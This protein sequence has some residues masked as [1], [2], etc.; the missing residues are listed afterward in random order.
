MLNLSAQGCATSTLA[1]GKDPVFRLGF[2]P[3]PKR[4]KRSNYWCFS[5]KISS[6]RAKDQS[7]SS[8]YVAEYWAEARPDELRSNWLENLQTH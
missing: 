5:A 8:Y 7:I 6:Y 1:P 3:K 2:S 4:P